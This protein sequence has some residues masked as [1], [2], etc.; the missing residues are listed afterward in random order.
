MKKTEAL[1]RVIAL[2]ID[3]V[4]V[5]LQLALYAYVWFAV[6]YPELHAPRYNQQGYYLGEGLVLYHRGHVLVLAIYFILLLFFMRTYG[7]G[8]TGYQLPV[9]VFLSQI[10]APRK[11]L[12]RRSYHM[13][14]QTH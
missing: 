14:E 12:L 7:A 2:H 3:F 10:F 4:A 9:R 8:R 11:A 5:L 13:V 1:K 6:Y